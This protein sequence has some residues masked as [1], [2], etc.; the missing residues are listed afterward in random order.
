MIRR[1]AVA[2][3]FY[4]IGKE[5]LKKAVDEYLAF[6]VDP[7]KVIGVMSPHAGYIYSGKTAG[8]TFASCKIPGKCI[9]LAPS[10]TGIG[11]KVAI[12]SEGEWMTPLGNTPIDSNLAKKLIAKCHLITND[13]TAHVAE[14]SLEVQIPFL[15]FARP[16]V[17]IVPISLQYISFDNCEV[18]G[19]AIADVI[20]ESGE[21]ILIVASTDM[22]HYE[23]QDVTIKKDDLAIEKIE[24]LDP[25]GLLNVCEKNNIT[26]CGVIPVA[27]MLIAAKKLGAN[28]A[29]LI[30]HTTSGDFAGDYDSVVGYA[31][32]TVSCKI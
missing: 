24:A 5:S 2:G 22:N 16:D 15:Q 4:P 30:E 28:Q 7:K 21:D 18:L 32:M 14:H 20:K 25:K 27:V 9:V 12:M 23:S 19:N 31:G 11:S 13:T 26:M 1:P 17:H 8:R 3:Q 6:D 10:H 29:E